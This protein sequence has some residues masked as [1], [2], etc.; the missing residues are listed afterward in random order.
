MKTL[1]I[2]ILFVM[3]LSLVGC[4]SIQLHYLDKDTRNSIIKEYSLIKNK[5][6]SWAFDT[7]Q[8]KSF[9][10]YHWIYPQ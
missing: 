6:K 9:P 4:S 7:I 8:H 10:F 3:V 2:L 5:K 1:K